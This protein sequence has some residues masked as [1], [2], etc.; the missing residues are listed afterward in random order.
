MIVSIRPPASSPAALSPIRPTSTRTLALAT[1]ALHHFLHH[2]FHQP[3]QLRLV[4]PTILHAQ[5]SFPCRT[6]DARALSCSCSNQLAVEFCAGAAVV[7]DAEGAAAAAAAGGA[8][9]S[10]A[11]EFSAA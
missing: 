7:A 3:G 6:A 5:R 9:C 8:P 10:A 2:L 11:A 4:R 1:D